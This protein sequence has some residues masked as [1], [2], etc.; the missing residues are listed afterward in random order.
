LSIATEIND[1]IDTSFQYSRN[2]EFNAFNDSDIANNEN[3]EFISSIDNIN[4]NTD[5]CTRF[6]RVLKWPTRA[7]K[8]PVYTQTRQINYYFRTYSNLKERKK[9]VP[10]SFNDTDDNI[11]PIE[12]NTPKGLLDYPM[13]IEN[14]G[15]S[16]FYLQDNE[17]DRSN[18]NEKEVTLT[19]TAILQETNT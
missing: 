14:E 17:E 1:T 4:S 9:T 15:Y 11:I 13:D 19:T 12:D 10:L 18:T 5:N 3:D 16:D 2:E 7:K 6:T 8:G